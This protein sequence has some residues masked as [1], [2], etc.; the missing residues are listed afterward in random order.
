MKQRCHTP[1]EITALAE[2]EPGDPRRA[3]VD[4]CPRCQAVLLSFQEFL[5]AEPLPE[6]ARPK[7]ASK[8]L[9]R[10]L[11]REILGSPSPDAAPEAAADP[12]GP[13]RQSWREHLAG[14]NRRSWREHLAG[15]NRRSW[16][17]HLAG[18][19]RPPVLA[20]ALAGAVV[21]LAILL[22]PGRTPTEP[23]PQYRGASSETAPEDTG[24]AHDFIATATTAL[25]D[26]GWL[27]EW[28]L[29][30]ETD[31]AV[32]ILYAAD[33]SELVR[34]EVTR[35]HQLQLAASADHEPRFPA[36]ARYWRV[37]GLQGTEEVARSTLQAFESAQP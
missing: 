6:G 17:E 5:A 2:L 10:V 12:A 26:G 7:L 36:A 22:I 28:R 18:L 1:E 24:D 13:N 14:P 34:H 4:A 27:L 16:R 9:E 3:H 33:L 15:P 29:P 11:Q 8:H 37:L 30:S 23:A 35:E 32:V 19:L 25:A 20:P 31:R 21:V